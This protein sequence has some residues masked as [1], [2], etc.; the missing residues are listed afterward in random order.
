MPQPQEVKASL[1][2][3]TLI[4]IAIIVII[5]RGHKEHDRLE[6]QVD[7]LTQEVRMLREDIAELTRTLPPPAEAPPR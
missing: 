3:G 4:L 6:K 2:C 1:G 5:F 7:A